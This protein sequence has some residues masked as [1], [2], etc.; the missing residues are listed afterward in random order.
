[1]LQCI[2]LHHLIVS[3]FKSSNMSSS[4]SNIGLWDGL[5]WKVDRRSLVADKS[6]LALNSRKVPHINWRG[7]ISQSGVTQCPPNLSEKLRR[8]FWETSQDDSTKQWP[9]TTPYW[10]NKTRNKF[11]NRCTCTT[12]SF[13]NSVYV[14]NETP[15][16]KG[17]ATEG[18]TF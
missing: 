6:F 9:L 14:K 11:L 18:G 10:E 8:W 4:A 17:C 1:M 15:S 13:L 16:D 3:L 5:V 12:C 2:S 7:S